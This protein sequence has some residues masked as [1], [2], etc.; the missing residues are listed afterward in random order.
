MFSHVC[1]SLNNYFQS[2][3]SEHS[4]APL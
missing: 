2:T 1:T 3:S 4:T